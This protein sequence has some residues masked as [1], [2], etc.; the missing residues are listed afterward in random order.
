VGFSFVSR[1]H[2]GG[3]SRVILQRN[4]MGII[5][6]RN[7]S[8]CSVS[9]SPLEK[10]LVRSSYRMHQ[11]LVVMMCENVH[12]HSRYV[13]SHVVSSGST[14][15]MSLTCAVQL[16]SF[17]TMIGTSFAFRT[18]FPIKYKRQHE[19]LNCC[20]IVI[21]SYFHFHNRATFPLSDTSCTLVSLCVGR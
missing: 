10:T 12:T 16:H 17:C 20:A 14:D 6:T 8:P 11:S 4:R 2:V 3:R 7:P 18:F 15:I 1:R 5:S 19:A 21:V 13:K 9:H